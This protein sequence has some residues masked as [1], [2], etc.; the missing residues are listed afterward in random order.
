MQ[1][2][3]LKKGTFDVAAIGSAL[4][5]ITAAVSEDILSEL[6]LKKGSMHLIDEEKSREILKHLDD[7][8]LKLSPGGS[9]ANTAAGVRDLGGSGLY[10]SSVG[11]DE[12]GRLF[13]RQTK[14]AGVKIVAAVH[15]GMSGHAIAFITP[16]GERTFATHLGAAKKLCAEDISAENILSAAVLHIEGYILEPDS[17]YAACLKAVKTAKAGGTVVSVDLSDSS[18]VDRVRDR[19]ESVVKDFADIVFAN[20]EEACAFVGKRNPIE[21]LH[22][23]GE[24]CSLA[25]LKR[26]S[27]GSIIKTAGRTYEIPAVK[28]DV[29]N[30]NGAGDMYA[31][32]IIYGLARG[33]SPEKAGRLAS[34]AAALIVGQTSAR[35]ES[36][37]NAKEILSAEGLL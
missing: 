19:L 28:V 3:K 6:G 5:D 13:V 31:A 36:P 4:M 14:R 2:F 27:D 33:F 9:S 11:D 21:A 37:V 15:A 30:T 7:S 12:C 23:L 8:K 16:D 25:V 22:E 24:Y 26:G 34:A 18:L 32:G 20:E 1:E 10:I 35:L 29:A 17:A